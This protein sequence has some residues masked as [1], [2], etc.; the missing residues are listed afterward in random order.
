MLCMATQ[1]YISAG[2]LVEE[3]EGL[4]SV[5]LVFDTSGSMDNGALAKGF[6]LGFALLDAG[7]KVKW[8]AIDRRVYGDFVELEKGQRSDIGG[9][10]D[11]LCGRGGSEVVANLPKALEKWR[12]ASGENPSMMMVVSDL[13]DELGA[14]V[15]EGMSG[16][17]CVFMNVLDD[18]P[19]MNRDVEEKFGKW[20]GWAG[21]QET[22]AMMEASELSKVAEKGSR[23]R[24]KA[25]I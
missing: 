14:D 9:L 16:V 18:K 23:R 20:A 22:I 21:L 25:L 12:E 10:L 7:V 4:S 8:V 1:T 5:A 13:Y 3:I 11:R 17:R 15:A 6:E 24:R 2:D 19:L